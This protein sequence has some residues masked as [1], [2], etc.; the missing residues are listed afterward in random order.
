MTEFCALWYPACQKLP[1]E[2]ESFA[3][4]GE[5]LEVNVA[6]VD[7]TGQPGLSRQFIVTALLLFIIVKMVNLDTIRVQGLR[8][9]SETL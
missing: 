8:R 5:V 3:E 2:W 1:P 9:T 6:K 4:W 7:V